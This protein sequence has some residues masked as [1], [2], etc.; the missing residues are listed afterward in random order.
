MHKLTTFILVLFLVLSKSYSDEYSLFTAAEGTQFL[1]QN[2]NLKGWE[3]FQANTIWYPND[4][5]V[6]FDFVNGK[7]SYWYY[8]YRKSID[9]NNPQSWTFLLSKV[10]DQ[11]TPL[12]LGIEDDDFLADFV[13]LP[14][15]WID[16]DMLPM[17]V[18]AN[19]NLGFYLMENFDKVKEFN[20]L[21]TPRYITEEEYP[22]GMWWLTLELEGQKDIAYCIF[23]SS[24]LDVVDCS[25]PEINS[26]S[27][28]LVS[29]ITCYPNPANDFLMI[30][31]PPQ[32]GNSKFYEIKIYNSSG[33][34]VLSHIPNDFSNIEKIDI[35]NL[36]SGNYYLKYGHIVK[37]F[38]IMR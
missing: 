33:I 4:S 32:Q 26:I 17:A 34:C 27:Q 16:S 18:Q 15:D 28:I 38:M 14:K 21:L 25:V 23:N 19:S 1:E 10:N 9:N 36:P 13:K 7:A 35:S 2:F 29:N 30:K 12:D 6:I 3:L 22:D 5:T 31:L 8:I 20:V 37:Q 11:F 24:T